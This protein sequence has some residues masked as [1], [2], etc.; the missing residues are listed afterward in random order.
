MRYRLMVTVLAGVL[1][2]CTGCSLDVESFLQ[3]PLAQEEQQK[4]QNALETYIRDSGNA[5]IRYTLQYPSEGEY[6]SAFILCDGNGNP[7]ESDTA[8][9]VS[10]AV[11][12]YE[13]T[14][15]KEPHVNLLRL[16]GEEWVSVG[17]LVGVGTDVLKVSFGDLDGDGVAELLAG[18]ST[19]NSRDH[20]LSVMSMAEGLSMLSDD[21][22]YTQLFVCDVEEAEYDSLLLLRIGDGNDVTAT[23]SVL[24]N[25]ALTDIDQA[26]LDGY[27]QQFGAVE[28]CELG[29]RVYGVYVDAFKSGGTTV[30]E[31]IYLDGSGLHTPF[32]NKEKGVTTATARRTGLSF[33]DIDGDGQIEIPISRLLPDQDAGAKGHPTTAYLTV[34]RHWDYLT[35]EWTDV[36]HSVV[37]S[38]DN[39]VVALDTS[40][41][42][43]M[44]T[45]YEEESHLL[46]LCDT[47]DEEAWLRIRPLAED[48]KLQA[49]YETLVAA[50]ETR[51]G[52]QVWYDEERLDMQKIRY[53][54][55]FG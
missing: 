48:E 38:V 14:A 51:S 27:I 46:T 26:P 15:S 31:L 24:R 17:D 47:A 9:D 42:K 13:M 12:F 34:W 8:E 53:M 41:R 10:M 55:S 39:Y 30:T 23:L 49:G 36:M 19:Y 20:R 7:V 45:R 44:T 11:A 22:L 2:F 25:G 4:I 3:P 54:I 28:L 40:Q 37:N 16:S 29:D 1:L 35:G 21:R 32:Y 50:T 5:G 52:F 43:G 18:W 6:T 33:Q